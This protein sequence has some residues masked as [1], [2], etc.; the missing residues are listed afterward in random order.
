MSYLPKR[1][2]W[3]HQKEALT[4][5]AGKTLFAY[6]LG[7]RLGKTK[8]LLDDFGRLEDAGEV[9]NLFVIAPGGVYM[10]WEP[11]I[12]TDLADELLNRALVHVWVSGRGGVNATRE[13]KAFMAEAKRPRILLMNVEALSSVPEARTMAVNFLKSGPAILAIDESTIIKNH[14]AKRTKFIVDELAELADH[15]RILSGLPTPRSPLDIWSQFYFL[16]WKILGHASFISFAKR[17]ATVTLDSARGAGGTIRRFWKITAPYSDVEEIQ[18]MIAPYS[19]RK[20]LEDVYDVPENRYSFRDIEMTGEQKK[21]YNGMR[22]YATAQLD[23]LAHVTATIVIAQ[24]LKLHQI[25][26]GHVTDEEGKIHPVTENRTKE[27]LALLDEYDGKAIIWC[28]YDYDITKISEALG[29]EY[30]PESVARFWGGN[31]KTRESEEK[32]FLNDPECR[33]MV[34]TP[35]AGGR[36]RTWTVA[37]LIVYYSS[38]NDLEHRSQSEERGKGV[39][40][41][42]HVAYVD[43]RVP[44]TV[45]ELIIEGLRGKIDLAS[46]VTGDDYKK[47]LI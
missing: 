46:V 44:G 20:K 24:M 37:N 23:E 45:D 36:G 14:K 22:D 11:A 32:R 6:L 34:A 40:K 9:Q 31:R 1:K 7:M 25:L 39:G 41:T 2:P 28:S 5:S 35:A 10:T 19:F 30:G 12:A 27:L 43:L 38:T 3:K 21:L 13:K 33:F 18:K 17:Y 42:D 47:W 26:C 16:D 15:R 8:I 4:K 29:E